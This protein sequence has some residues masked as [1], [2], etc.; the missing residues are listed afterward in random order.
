MSVLERYEHFST[1]GI[2]KACACCEM[3]FG[4][5]LEDCDESEGCTKGEVCYEHN[6]IAEFARSACD[7]CGSRLAGA[8]Y[9]AHAREKETG[10]IEHFEIC[11]D[12]LLEMEG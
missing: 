5:W 4:D 2:L 9:V 12:C 1:G 3:E 6:R 8:R 11:E 7:L 10:E